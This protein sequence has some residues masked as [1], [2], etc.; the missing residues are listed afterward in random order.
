MKQPAPDNAATV[1]AFTVNGRDVSLSVRADITLAE[2]LRDQLALTGTKI[3]CGSGE[4]GA[5]TVIVDGAAVPAC[6]TPALLVQGADIQTVE[7]LAIEDALHPLQR[8]FIDNGA[9]QCGFCTAGMLMSATA[10]L[11]QN[12]HPSE[13][14]IRMA[15]QGNICRCTGYVQIL[16]AVQEAAR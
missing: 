14:D 5:C 4:C 3:G 11:K 7:G 10:L 9:F 6:I 12:P 16:K 13:A 15:L 2:L 8:A 1:M